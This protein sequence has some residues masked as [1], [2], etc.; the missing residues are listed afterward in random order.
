MLTAARNHNSR[1]RGRGNGRN[2]RANGQRFNQASSKKKDEKSKLKKFH[3][4]VKGKLPEYSFEEVNRELL[5]SLEL[6]D[7]EKADDIIDSVRDLSL[8]DLDVLRPVLEVSTATL[9]ADRDIEN[10]R[11]KE[12]YKYDLKKWDQR[13]DALANNKRKLHAKILKFC[14]ETMEEKLERDPEF[15]GILYRD[16]IELLKKIKKYMT[17][18]EETD[19][20]F[21]GLWE[22]LTKLVT[23]RQGG[24]E[25]PNEFRK[26]VE[27]RAKTA[28]ALLGDDCLE[29]FIEST[30]GYSKLPE[31]GDNEI[32]SVEQLAYKSQAWE[33]FQANVIIF[34]SDRS[35]YQSL[36][37]RMNVQYM[38]IH[39]DY[40]LRD[41]YPKTV[42]HATETLNRHKHDNRKSKNVKN[43]SGNGNTGP[44]SGGGT[45][46]RDSNRATAGE[47]GTN[48]AQTGAGGSATRACYVCGA[49]DHIAPN[50]PNRN[51]PQSQWVKP[52]KYRDY[53]ALQTEAGNSRSNGSR[54]QSMIQAG[55]TRAEAGEDRAT[56][57]DTGR[58]NVQWSFMQSGRFA[59]CDQHSS[60]DHVALHQDDDDE[61]SLIQI[62]VETR[63]PNK[64]FTDQLDNGIHLDSGSTFHLG[65]T[66]DLIPGTIKR[67]PRTFN[68]GC[69]VG[70]R[71]LTE[72][73]ISK[74]F[75]DMKMK[76]DDLA[77]AS[78]VG[79][80]KAVKDGYH[81][82]MDTRFWN[83]FLLVNK[84][85][86]TWK[87]PH[88]NGLYTYM[89]D[90]DSGLEEFTD[91]LGKQ[92]IWKQYQRVHMLNEMVEYDGDAHATYLRDRERDIYDMIVDDL[93]AGNP[94][95]WVAD[96][97][98]RARFGKNQQVQ[99]R[100]VGGKITKKNIHRI[101]RYI[102]G[103]IP[104]EYNGG[105][106]NLFAN[107][108]LDQR[109]L[110]QLRLE[111]P[112]MTD[113]GGLRVPDPQKRLPIND[114][115]DI[116][117]AFQKE[118]LEYQ[119]RLEYARAEQD[120]F[121]NNFSSTGYNA[122]QSVAENMEGFTKKQVA[123]AT[124]ARSGMHMAGAPNSRV[125]AISVRSGLFKNCPIEE[126]DIK[127]AD[128][129]YGPSASMI[130]GKTKRPT[131]EAI[132]DDWVE[133]PPELIHNNQE[134]DLAIDLLIANKV[135]ALTGVDKQIKGRH[136]IPLP[137]RTK[138]AL[139]SGID[140]ILRVYNHAGFSIGTIYCD[141]EFKPV[142]D[143]VKDEMDVHMNYASAGEHEPTAERNV[144]HLKAMMRAFA[145][146]CYFRAIPKLL[147]I[148]FGRRAA[149]TSNYYPAKGGISSYYSPHMILK[150]RRVDFSKEC[151]AE[152]GA[153][154]QGFGHETHRN[155]R[156]RTV[157]AIYLG[158]A[159]NAQAGHLLLNLAT[160]KEIKRNRIKELPMTKQVIETVEQMA[161]DEGV[162]ALRTYSRRT[163]APILDADL[164][165]GVDPDEL[166]DPDYNPNED[167]PTKS[168]ENLRIELIDDDEVN[169]LIDD[170]GEDFI[171]DDNYDDEAV[172]RITQRL[173]SNKKED[174]DSDDEDY[175][176]PQQPEEDLPV[177]ATEQQQMLDDMAKEL[178]EL[179][180]EE[181]SSKIFFDEDK[182]VQEVDNSDSDDDDSMPDLVGRE[183]GKGY[184]SSD[185][186]DSDDEGEDED[187]GG[188]DI[189]TIGSPPEVKRKLR[190]GKAFWQKGIKMR[191]FDGVVNE[192]LKFSAYHGGDGRKRKT[193]FDVK[194]EQMKRR[195]NRIKNLRRR[196][197]K[198][199]QL[200]QNERRAYHEYNKPWQQKVNE[201]NH[202]L[203]FQQF[204]NN[205]KEFYARDH[206]QLI[207]RVI[208]Q[209]R[210][211]IQA[212]DGV[213]F[214]QQYYITKG[215]KLFGEEGR[216]A[217]MKE[218][219]QLVQRNC[220]EPKLISELTPEERKKAVE[221]MMLLAEK[222]DGTIKG[223]YVFKGSETRGWLSREETSSPTASQE[224]I[225]TTCV[226]DAHEDRDVMS[227][228]IPNAF[229]QTL[230]PEAKQ[231]KERVTMK[232]T[233]LLIQYMLE[234][235]PTYRQ[236]IVYENGRRVIYVVVLRAIYGQLEASL[237][238]YK[239]L[240][241]DLEGQ[242][243]VF[244]PYDPCI[245]NR[246]VNG[247]QQTIRFHV[248]DLMSSHVDP[249][250]NDE[251]Y[252]W[253]DST[254]GD[255]KAVTCT[256]GDVHTY[257]GMTLD[258][259]KRGKVKIRM[260]DYVDRMLDEF[261]VTFRSDEVQETPASATL[262]EPGRGANLDPQRHETFHSFVAK[263]LFL[264]KRARLDIAPTVAIL[265][266]RVQAPTQGDWNRLVRLMRYLH[267]TKGWHLTL[268]ADNLRVIKW[269]IDASF[270]THP[271]FKSHTGATMTMGS[272]AMQIMT[273]KQKLNSRSS[274]EAELIGVDDAITQVLWTKLF[275]EAQ[276]YPIE[277]NI[278]Y[279]DNKS[280]ILLE[281]NGRSSAGKR[282]RALNIRYFFVTDQVENG[283]VT[284]EYMPTD[285]MWADFMTKPLQG[286]KFRKFRAVIQGDQD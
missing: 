189:V 101:F 134:L 259:S 12:A 227:V 103:D 285:E 110:S 39:Q 248:D 272:G 182:N 69:N 219:T 33:M 15:E 187:D 255:L 30:V 216:K 26:R 235:D 90:Q 214:I 236:Y 47:S 260:D 257:L 144:Q 154:V 106:V 1:G 60:V 151:A 283:N 43:V 281:T 242:G 18:S 131:P 234:L 65:R 275:M 224:A 190:N 122:V 59:C 77:R 141:L 247:S 68:Y 98:K 256:R 186:E 165:A 62:E 5:K 21:F 13:V 94:S 142:F 50:C 126:A 124:K 116:M 56:R 197:R 153:Y 109:K 280:S 253:M 93:V 14:S 199:V 130:K 183:G 112:Y 215:L 254:Y 273:R 174:L 237:L 32:H 204:N 185:D 178:E 161:R 87:F 220:W 246:M 102:Y 35:R 177:S 53:S 55:S 202:N 221:A 249:K 268:S 114:P 54:N 264:S 127:A 129:I 226:I 175:E 145:E 120:R 159:P 269:Y 61:G 278:L 36:I 125:F 138:D 45:R 222:N 132:V 266:S 228:D 149:E 201:T 22:A 250:V 51:R 74:A 262:L 196:L 208:Q 135:V 4:L 181:R 100:Y 7:L 193:I 229:I 78:V 139:F 243:F 123:R 71:D 40:D 155:Q 265:A 48:L 271:D 171:N 147:T 11:F 274:T 223:R 115:F 217:A 20:E 258:F 72:E 92:L 180:E 91:A 121:N 195:K 212:P 17:T 232:I 200:Q 67:L 119:R 2:G 164:L 79:I 209:I 160:G 210:D 241:A 64:T 66:K 148:A 117:R 168:D 172:N 251:F 46:A 10:E 133:I 41:T 143:A 49:R 277:K 58:S 80:S 252:K 152:P 23:C 28:K 240:R 83:G 276:G 88:S 267:S 82:I 136:F 162:A 19:W 52:E 107:T 24:S 34:N 27:D 81:V 261:P 158:P 140:D 113:L 198:E 263:S 150:K 70:S 99:E 170:M 73:G 184:D 57:A 25:T 282:S 205:K 218:L 105:V 194:R 211:R 111:N 6:S 166:Y 173:R 225:T 191:P 128:K 9:R 156:T 157:D 97:V 176:Q 169:D 44:A 146:R 3:P 167:N 192:R 163:G 38:V 245:A 118:K 63:A 76:K 239:K 188:G 284:I 95:E 89:E 207:A 104:L 108:Y 203:V 206:A 16:P 179:E 96:M 231:G 233:G 42:H 213:S 86:D 31:P 137:S 286:E 29:R 279:Q 244:N 270:A 75:P 84:D 85:G 37:D 8:L 230:I 238:W